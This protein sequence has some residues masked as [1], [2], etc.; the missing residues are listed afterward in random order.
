[1]HI[2]TI[3]LNNPELA[4][5]LG[6]MLE[7]FR[8]EVA[9]AYG[10]DWL[11]CSVHDNYLPAH[12][13]SPLLSPIKQAGTSQ[14]HPVPFT[15][16]PTTSMECPPSPASLILSTATSLTESSQTTYTQDCTPL[17]PNMK[18]HHTHML[19][20]SK[21]HAATSSACNAN[22]TK[23]QTTPRPSNILPASLTLSSTVTLSSS[24]LIA[25]TILAIPGSH[26]PSVIEKLMK[27]IGKGSSECEVIRNIYLFTVRVLWESSIMERIR[28]SLD[29]A[30]ALV[31][32]MLNI[33]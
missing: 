18:S 21:P 7:I 12:V 5:G 13:L 24:S 3:L 11:L 19:T 4:N 32:L 8:D 22:T 17:T 33:A 29:S 28:L 30:K 1:M 31:G 6:Q 10:E 23:L 27:N 25:G 15:N 2:S 16:A 20:H 26:L 9:A 14:Q